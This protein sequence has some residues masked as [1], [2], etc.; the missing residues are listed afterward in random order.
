MPPHWPWRVDPAPPPLRHHNRVQPHEHSGIRGIAAQQ[1]GAARQPERCWEWDG[2]PDPLCIL[3]AGR[4]KTG[5]RCPIAGSHFASTSTGM[6][7]GFRGVLVLGIETVVL[8]AM[9]RR[10]RTQAGWEGFRFRDTTARGCER[11]GPTAA[12]CPSSSWSG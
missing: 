9:R 2:V 4:T 11:H 6:V 7:R 5:Q 1:T 8:D 10:L 12:R 3:Q